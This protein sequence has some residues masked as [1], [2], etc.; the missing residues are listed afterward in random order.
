MGAGPAGALESVAPRMMSRNMNVMVTS[1]GI[2]GGVVVAWVASRALQGIL[3]GVSATNGV[4]V[5]AASGVLLAAAIVAAWLP[6]R[7]AG[8]ADAVA[9]LRES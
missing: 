8:G 4:A 7:R 5:I 2:A 1:V 3:F 6:A 9:S